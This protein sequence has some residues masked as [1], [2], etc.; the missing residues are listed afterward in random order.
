[1]IICKSYGALLIHGF[2]LIASDCLH[3]S[4]WRC[5]FLTHIQ[6]SVSPMVHSADS[7]LPSLYPPHLFLLPHHSLYMPSSSPGQYIPIYCGWQWVWTE[8]QIALGYLMRAIVTWRLEK[9]ACCYS[10]KI[11]DYCLSVV[12][13]LVYYMPENTTQ[14]D[15]ETDRTHAC[16]CTRKKPVQ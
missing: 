8:L 16:T 11:N 13:C 3:S 10:T 2:E 12:I 14:P 7:G 6:K 9:W 5:V 15:N 4:D 1:M